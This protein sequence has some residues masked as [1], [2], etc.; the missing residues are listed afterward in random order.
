MEVK[1]EAGS[2]EAFFISTVEAIL[3]YGC[4]NWSLTESMEK[5]LNGYYTRML[6]KVLNVHW[7]SHTP[8][9]RLYGNLPRVADKITVGTPSVWPL[10]PP[11]RSLFYGSQTTERETEEGHRLP[12]WTCLKGTQERKTPASWRP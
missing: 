10:L 1:Y 9:E 5:S 8:N 2:Q 4:E 11:P 7:S 12:M 3:L 6:W